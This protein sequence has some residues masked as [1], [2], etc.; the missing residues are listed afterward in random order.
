MNWYSVSLLFKSLHTPMSADPPLW[1]ESIRLFSANSEE[2]ARQKA[3]KYGRS[4]EINY[5]TS[6][7]QINWE[8]DRIERVYAI[9][10]IEAIDGFEVFSRF[11]RDSEVQSLLIPFED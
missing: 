3:E 1:E 7:D 5:E 11:L 4:L 9:E 6:K 2:G 10:S 8:F